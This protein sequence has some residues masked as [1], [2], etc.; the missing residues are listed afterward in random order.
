MPEKIIGEISHGTLRNSDL[1]K[2]FYNVY[3]ELEPENAGNIL[4]SW[5]EEN[6][7]YFLIT[8]WLQEELPYNFELEIIG[9]I[10]N[11]WSEDS[12]EIL[13]EL[14]DLLGEVA[15]K[16]FYF[17]A[18]ESDG[19]SFGF[20]VADYL[21][22]AI[23]EMLIETS[24]K[25]LKTTWP[26]DYSIIYYNKHRDTFCASCAEEFLEDED[27]PIWAYEDLSGMD[28]DVYCCHCGDKID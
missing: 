2:T 9:K 22:I 18:S 14:F 1:I 15:P 20:W 3:K 21:G 28:E 24:G 4:E 25:L 11:D 13:S 10:K 16:G 19:S 26:G 5:K 7:N 27:D 23:Q 17:G 6:L 12:S 8:K